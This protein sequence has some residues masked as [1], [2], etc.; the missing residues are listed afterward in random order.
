MNTDSTLDRRD[1]ETEREQCHDVRW[2]TRT[3][4][5][6]RLLWIVVLALVVG[7]AVGVF[8]HA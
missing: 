8:T 4:K 6:H 5:S 1:R 7:V 2:P 3:R